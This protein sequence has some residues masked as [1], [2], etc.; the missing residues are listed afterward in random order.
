[1]KF[2]KVLLSGAVA[3]IVALFS[4][5]NASALNA[6]P[7]AV[8]L[9]ISAKIVVPDTI[10]TNGAVVTGKLKTVSVNNKTL[11]A[12]LNASPA[13]QSYI[14]NNI[15]HSAIS[16]SIPAGSYFVWDMFTEDVLVTNKNGFSFDVDIP[17]SFYID[18]D[19]DTV[20]GSAKLADVTG[21]GSEMDVTGIKF[22]FYDNNGNKLE[23]EYGEG[24]FNWTYGA[25][26]GGVQQKAISIKLSPAAYFAEVNGVNAITTT[27]N[28]SGN[29]SSADLAPFG[30][31]DEPYWYWENNL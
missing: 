15:T 26:S 17:V 1:M 30:A 22:Y 8:N 25:V 6:Y 14:T 31:L 5:S 11:I 12:L 19:E 21:A 10:T 28:V 20:V 3:G 9:N 29:G 7:H 4:A 2:T 23:P 24:D 18:Y 16:N 27:F 13:V